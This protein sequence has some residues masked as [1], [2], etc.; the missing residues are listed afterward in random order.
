LGV[1]LRGGSSG[2]VGDIING[3]AEAVEKKGVGSPLARK[4][5]KSEGK[6]RGLCA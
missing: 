3:A 4:P 6:I 2:L 5:K 1:F